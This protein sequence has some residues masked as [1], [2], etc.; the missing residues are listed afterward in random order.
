MKTD[1]FIDVFFGISFLLAL[2]FLVFA[3]IYTAY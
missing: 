1:R 2:G 3:G